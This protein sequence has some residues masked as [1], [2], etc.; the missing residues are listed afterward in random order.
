M[1]PSSFGRRYALLAAYLGADSTS[2]LAAS[3]HN[4]AATRF[5]WNDGSVVHDHD[6]TVLAG[7]SAWNLATLP[8]TPDARTR[9]LQPCGGC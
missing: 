9:G 5:D 2:T 6:V 1:E 8:G 4:Q 3:G 7:E